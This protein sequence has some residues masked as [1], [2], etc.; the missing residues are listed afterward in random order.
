M[1]EP[2]SNLP[3][4]HPYLEE[5]QW[6]GKADL[7]GEIG[8]FTGWKM[9][10]NV[11]VLERI[12]QNILEALVGIL[13]GRPEY[14]SVRVAVQVGSHDPPL[15]ENDTDGGPLVKIQV[16]TDVSKTDPKK[17]GAGDGAV[18]RPTKDP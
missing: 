16:A 10:P 1:G 17:R 12:P 11:L 3:D 7:V 15:A 2:C 18:S 4:H 9:P 8:S 13:E 14:E 6:K 5:I